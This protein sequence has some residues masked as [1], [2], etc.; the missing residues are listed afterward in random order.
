MKYESPPTLRSV[1]RKSIRTSTITKNHATTTAIQTQAHWPGP[2]SNT[3]RI[4]S[5]P[6][7]RTAV[8]LILPGRDEGLF[9]IR[10]RFSQGAHRGRPQALEP[11]AFRRA[12]ISSGRPRLVALTGG[13]RND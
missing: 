11:H 5:S 9:T 1:S 3:D 8:D 7:L 12:A 6:S 2:Q 4:M 13:A 10:S